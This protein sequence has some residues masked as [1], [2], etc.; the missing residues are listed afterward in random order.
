MEK[1]FK[2]ISGLLAFAIY[3]L[4]L[5]LL[6]NYFNHK[7]HRKPIHFVKKNDNRI[8]VALSKPSEEK[9]VDTAKL[10]RKKKEDLA[11]KKEHKKKAIPKISKKVQKSVKK[12]EKPRDKKRTKKIVKKKERKRNKTSKKKI[13]VNSLFKKI[14]DKQPVKNSH[15]VTKNKSIKNDR[16]RDRGIRNAYFAKIEETLQNW[17]A[18]SEFA[19]QRVKVWLRIRNDGS[20]EFRLLSPSN[21]EDFNTGLI[22]YLQ[23][24]QRIGFEPHQNSKAYELNVEFVAKE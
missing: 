15:N 9:R 24:L 18:Q 11:E 1:Y 19:G 3:F 22:Q 17:P 13:N 16:N 7:S 8:T 5:G 10:P 21:N 2:I 14:D 23:Q 20:F 4:L 6:L 12:K